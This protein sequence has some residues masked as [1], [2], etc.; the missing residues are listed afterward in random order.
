MRNGYLNGNQTTW[1]NTGTRIKPLAFYEQD[2]QRR[3]AI[4]EL[5]G[6]DL[7]IPLTIYQM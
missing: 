1:N 7:M 5:W 3:I 2:L 4:H 6:G